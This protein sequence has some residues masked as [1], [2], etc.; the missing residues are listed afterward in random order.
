MPGKETCAVRERMRF[1][2]EMEVGEVSFSELCQRYAISRET[3]YKWCA[4]YA[5]EGPRGLEDRSRARHTQSEATSSAMCAAI[6]DL[7]ARH[8]SWGPKKL[9]ANSKPIR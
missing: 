2:S 6:V 7:R 3:G 4:R 1:V 9:R 5:A 8:P